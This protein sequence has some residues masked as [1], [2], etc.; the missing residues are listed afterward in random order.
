MPETFHFQLT[1]HWWKC[2]LMHPR[3]KCTYAYSLAMNAIPVCTGAATG[4]LPLRNFHSGPAVAAVRWA[5]SGLSCA[6]VTHS[7]TTSENW[8]L[9][10]GSLTTDVSRSSVLRKL[11]IHTRMFGGMN[12]NAR[13]KKTLWHV[14]A[15]D[16]IPRNNEDA[17]AM[18]PYVSMNKFSLI[19]NF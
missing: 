17:C 18:A 9:K 19:L 15:T 10:S 8:K 11:E 7:R 4:G 3:L 5:T 13:Y 12:P 14:P 1:S 6:L 2:Q 16:V